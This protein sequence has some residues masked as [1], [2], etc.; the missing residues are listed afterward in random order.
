MWV[1]ACG[2]EEIGVY[3]SLRQ[4]QLRVEKIVRTAQTPVEDRRRRAIR[5]MA[6]FLGLAQRT[7]EIPKRTP[8]YALANICRA[9]ADEVL[10][11]P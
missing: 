8:L 7:G 9:L 6:N 3:S 1:A 10:S 11:K 4:A 2:T 5:Q